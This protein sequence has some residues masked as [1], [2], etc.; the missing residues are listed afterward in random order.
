MKKI[1]E[2]VG[3]NFSDS[4]LIDS[5]LTHSSYASD[6]GVES[7][8]RLE[9]LGDAVLGEV[10]AKY[11]YDNFDVQAGDLSK[12]RAKLVNAKI[13]ANIVI[14]LG[15]DKYVKTGRSIHNISHNIYADV[16]ESVL[17]AIYLDGGDYK[18]FV[19]NTLIVDKHNVESIIDSFTDYKTTLQELLAKTHTPFEYKVVSSGGDGECAHFDVA[20]VV[21]GKQVALCTGK[22]IKGAEQNC[23]K[24]YI[25]NITKNA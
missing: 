25:N 24:I 5:A 22:S 13:L 20:L 3:H 19:M 18:Q 16:Y 4:K 10:V 12:Y 11:L 2:I 1:N 7:Y 8:E 6:N 14:N 23:A 21:D 9:Y 17:G 15:L